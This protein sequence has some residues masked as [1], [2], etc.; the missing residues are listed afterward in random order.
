MDLVAFLDIGTINNSTHW[1]DPKYDF[2]QATHTA[3]AKVRLDLLHQAE[4]LLLSKPPVA[5]V[6]GTHKAI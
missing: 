5:L 1:S 6:I 4:E 3:D 2:Y